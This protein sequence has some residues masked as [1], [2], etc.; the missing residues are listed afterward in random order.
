MRGID[1]LSSKRPDDLVFAGSTVRLG[2]LYVEVLR[3][4]ADT[5][6]AA[7]LRATLGAMAAPLESS[8][9]TVHGAHFAEPTVGADN[10]RGRHRALGRGHFNGGGDSSP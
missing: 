8:T 6:A 10:C 7:L 4:G 2:E 1:G 5:Q 9:P 3:V